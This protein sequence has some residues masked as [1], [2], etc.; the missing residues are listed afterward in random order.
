METG[1]Q[2]GLQVAGSLFL[3]SPVF[4]SPTYLVPEDDT[5]FAVS[6]KA[7]GVWCQEGRELGPLRAVSTAS[8]LGRWGSSHPY[9]VFS[10]LVNS[11]S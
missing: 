2:L 8:A 4:H 11:V 1:E 6:D 7:D 9:C 5:G 10:Y 3:P